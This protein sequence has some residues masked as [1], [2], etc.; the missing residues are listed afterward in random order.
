MEG[1]WRGRICPLIS[2]ENNIRHCRGPA[3]M[4]WRT[5]YGQPRQ[6][7][8]DCAIVQLAISIG[9]LNRAIGDKVY[10]G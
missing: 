1:E 6:S 7:G 3:C 2:G 5:V 4:F 9:E 8:E 10:I